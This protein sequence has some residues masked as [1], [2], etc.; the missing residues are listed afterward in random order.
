MPAADRTPRQSPRRNWLS[1]LIHIVLVA[2]VCLGVSGTALSMDPKDLAKI[3]KMNA[4]LDENEMIDFITNSNKI[5][6]VTPDDEKA[7]KGAGVS[8]RVINSLK[9][10]AGGGTAPGGGEANLPR[11]IS[12]AGKKFEQSYMISKAQKEG[13]VTATTNAKRQADIAR[14]FRTISL[15]VPEF[16]KADKW[17][18]LKVCRTFIDKYRDDLKTDPALEE[19]YL[20]AHWC[21]GQAY[22]D[23]DLHY[24]AA[25]IL[26]EVV[27]VGTETKVFPQAFRALVSSARQ[28]GYYPKT[29]AELQTLYIEP[30]PPE[31][32]DDVHYFLGSFFKESISDYASA[33][34]EF[35]QVRSQSPL[36]PKALYWMG[37]M[38]ASEQLSQ[39][40]TGVQNF[41]EAI[42]ASEAL[43]DEEYRDIIELS[44]IA[45]ARVAYEVGNYDGALYYYQKVDRF[46]SRYPQVLF[47]S[48]WTYFLKGDY[49]RAVGVF[50]ALHSPYYEEYY[51]PDL[52]VLEATV[53]L[54]MCRYD[55]ANGALKVFNDTYLSRLPLLTQFLD[56]TLQK[57]DP[58]LFY[59]AIA[60][61][62]TLK[63]QG[64]VE[65]GDVLPPLFLESVL[66]DVKFYS[67]FKSV[68][69]LRREVR[70]LQANVE[71]LGEVGPDLVK[72]MERARDRKM[73][74]AGLRTQQI[75]A[76]VRDDLDNWEVNQTLVSI[77][78]TNAEKQLEEI[79]VQRIAQG[80][81]CDFEINEDTVLFLIADDW[82]Y[83]PFEGE[84]WADEVGAYKSYLS[85]HCPQIDAFAQGEE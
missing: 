8:D 19:Q 50:H 70:Y 36:Y 35:E 6:D 72:D 12:D 31:L 74:D 41:Q 11:I 20:T 32:Q 13:E 76:Q 34:S 75:L 68:E 59:Q 67:I 82:Q 43:D 73:I 63:E 14:D 10:T 85:D 28:A 26:Y 54:N 64:K 38:R 62:H 49:R 24:L 60:D 23:L 1:L 4:I 77:D 51:F 21:E 61:Y 39:L 15:M 48:S 65:D 57:G 25:P 47:E 5:Y 58:A 56:N 17:N 27:A 80:L 9:A 83:W 66:A 40:K 53:Y 30:L 69:E 29:M 81:S 84:Y 52:W 71:K 42:L 78:I 2:I 44:Y 22:H 79:C 3:K 16:D 33:V 46:S 37:V 55:Q 18:A 45:L 7:L